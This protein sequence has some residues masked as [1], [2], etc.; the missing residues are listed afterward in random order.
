MGIK[1]RTR[2]PDQPLKA[3]I[4]ALKKYDAV[5]PHAQIEVYRQNSVSVR[6]RVIDP[7]FHGK[8]R[9]QREDEL[10][11]TLQELPEEITAEISMLLLLTPAEAKKSFASLEFDHPVPS[12]F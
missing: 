3:I 8:S 1:L 11:G 10:W 5:H 4:E 6:I 9:A 2:R 7:D 12:R